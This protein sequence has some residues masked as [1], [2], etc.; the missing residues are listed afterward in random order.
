LRTGT[1]HRFGSAS[2]LGETQAAGGE[3]QLVQI[4]LVYQQHS[5]NLPLLQKYHATRNNPF[6]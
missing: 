3:Q 2:S 5:T 6:A 4:L 1:S